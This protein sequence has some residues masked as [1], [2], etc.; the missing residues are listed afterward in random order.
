MSYL[1][2]PIAYLE[3]HDFDDQGNLV[4]PQIPENKPVV[5]MLQSSWCPHCT[6]SKPDFQKFANSNSDEVFCATI[7]ADGERDSEKKLGE[8]IEV[9][10]PDFVGFPDYLLYING[11]RID[12]EITGRN[13][14]ALK[15]FAFN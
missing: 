15:K 7:Q 12:K 2:R 3:D 1:Y 6:N 5:I 8:R 10:K 9:L 13:E 14:K 4:N 11:Q